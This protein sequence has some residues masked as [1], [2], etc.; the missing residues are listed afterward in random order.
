MAAAIADHLWSTHW[1]PNLMNSEG[2]GTFSVTGAAGTSA[3]NTRD[4]YFAIFTILSALIHRLVPHF[5]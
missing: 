3:K 1:G 4:F 2:T 5:P